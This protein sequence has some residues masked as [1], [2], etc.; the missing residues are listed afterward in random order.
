MISL[1]AFAAGLL[2]KVGD[3]FFGYAVSA[4]IVIAA[5]VLVLFFAKETLKDIFK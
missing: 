1:L 3:N 2:K 5:A 4:V